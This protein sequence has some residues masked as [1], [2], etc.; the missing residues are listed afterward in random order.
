MGSRAARSN[1]AAVGARLGPAGDGGRGPPRPLPRH[2]AGEDGGGVAIA[3]YV[4]IA[5]C[6]ATA[7][8]SRGRPVSTYTGMRQ[9]PA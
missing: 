6:V 5:A 1:G 9:S 4:A 3:T 2:Q 8:G 7:A